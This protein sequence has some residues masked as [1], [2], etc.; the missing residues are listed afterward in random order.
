MFQFANP[1]YFFLLP[2]LVLAGWLMLRRRIRAGLAFSAVS[3]LPTRRRTWRMHIARA[4]PLFFLL[5]MALTIVA[6]A[7]PQTV[8]SHSRRS[9]DMIAVEMVVDISGS[10]EALDLSV[11]TPTGTKYRTRLDAVKE[12]FSEFVD[13]R[14]DDL[15]GLITFGGYAVTRVPL[16]A[17]HEALQHVLGGVEVPR[18]VYVDGQ[19]VNQEELLTAIGD[20]LA[21]G[22]ARLR[23][24]EPT[25][26]IVVLLSDGESN[27]GAIAPEAGIQVAREMGIKV[28]TIGIGT[29]GR[30]VA[31][32]RARDIFGRETFGRINVSLDEKLLRRIATQTGGRYFNVRDPRGLEKALEEIDELET[33][34]V[35]RDIYSQ[36]NELFPW[37][38]FPALGLFVAVTSLN[39]LAAK[40]LI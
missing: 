25:S 30:S 1:Y 36:Y 2:A 14:P 13:R 26:R 38:L 37:F 16:T 5:A 21:M 6:L 32:I 20:G 39:M 35:E 40:R 9:A 34:K 31:P 29:P 17:D 23:D 19:I 15:I 24:A 28:Y 12:T 11:R 18:Q 22:C 10:M 7:R 8:L 33:T 27:T 4:L 3:A